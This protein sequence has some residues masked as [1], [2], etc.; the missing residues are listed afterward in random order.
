MSATIQEI[1]VFFN[2]TNDAFFYPN[3][4]VYHFQSNSFQWLILSVLIDI[5]PV[6]DM[7]GLIRKIAGDYYIMLEMYEEASSE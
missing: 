6:T 4:E 3:V 5:N 2:E 7:D 1:F